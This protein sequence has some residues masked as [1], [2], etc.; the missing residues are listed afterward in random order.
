MIDLP[1]LDPMISVLG[2]DAA[3]YRV[4]GEK[5]QRTGSRR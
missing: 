3:I 1:L 4:T 5:P 2:P